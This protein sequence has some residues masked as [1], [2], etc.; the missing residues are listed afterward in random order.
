MGVGDESVGLGIGDWGWEIWVSDVDSRPTPGGESA[1]PNSSG[2]GVSK[3][4]FGVSGA[5]C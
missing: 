1:C 4:D 2:F 3:L 5:E